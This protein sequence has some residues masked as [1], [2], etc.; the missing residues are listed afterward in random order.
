MDAR[1]PP[2]ETEIHALDARSAL[3]APP[4][5]GW[6]GATR[7]FFGP[8]GYPPSGHRQLAQ[9][10]EMGMP[11]GFG[12]NPKKLYRGGT[13]ADTESAKSLRRGKARPGRLHSSGMLNAPCRAAR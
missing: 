2:A 9:I 10:R 8:L 11:V 5:A 4:A 1:A 3:G 13:C 7:S 12:K 6:H